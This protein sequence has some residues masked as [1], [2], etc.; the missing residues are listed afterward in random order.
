MKE[1]D[2][3]SVHNVTIETSE[4]FG[5]LPRVERTAVIKAIAAAGSHLI[6]SADFSSD[7]G[8]EKYK[9]AVAHNQ[10]QLTLADT[11]DRKINAGKKFDDLKPEE[12]AATLMTLGV[13]SD[14]VRTLPFDKLTQ[15]DQNKV[16]RAYIESV[17]AELGKKASK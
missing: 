14:I 9:A 2:F 11:I 17:N 13:T 8:I 5:K 7:E 6:D 3:T 15:S 12:M 4:K 10:T 1:F 16:M